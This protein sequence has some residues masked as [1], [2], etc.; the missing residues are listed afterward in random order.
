MIL[1]TVR[2]DAYCLVTRILVKLLIM[3]KYRKKLIRWRRSVSKNKQFDHAVYE[4]NL[5]ILAD[6]AQK[7]YKL[8][9]QELPA[10]QRSVLKTYLWLSSLLVAAE[11]T[12]FK[13]LIGKAMNVTWLQKDPS[14]F[15]YHISAASILLGLAV[16]CFGIDTM[17]GR[18]NRVMPY[19]SFMTLADTAHKEA[20]GVNESAT[21]LTTVI[22]SLNDSIINQKNEIHKVGIKLRTMSFGINFSIVLGVL[23]FIVF[24]LPKP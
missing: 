19:I 13:S 7:E 4:K 8:V 17:R 12:T 15:F 3:L 22:Q 23:A 21:T 11:V 1:S 24:A 9:A 18:K 14:I 6:H 16:F 2:G 10:Y 20:S 5:V